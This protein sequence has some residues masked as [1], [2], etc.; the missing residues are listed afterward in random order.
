MTRLGE[1]LIL[2]W[3]GG[4]CHKVQRDLIRLQEIY[5]FKAVGEEPGRRED[6]LVRTKM[7]KDKTARVPSLK[8]PSNK[9]GSEQEPRKVIINE[10]APDAKSPH[11]EELK[12]KIV[13]VY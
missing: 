8:S 6:N 13:R 12:I 7:E 9:N 3:V 2:D 4:D 5:H 10:R 1:R 11:Q